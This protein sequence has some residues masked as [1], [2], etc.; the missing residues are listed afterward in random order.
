MALRGVSDQHFHLLSFF[1]ILCDIMKWS[2]ADYSWWDWRNDALYTWWTVQFDNR[3]KGANLRFYCSSADFMI[4]CIYG[5]L[6]NKMMVFIKR[7]D[8]EWTVLFRWFYYMFSW[9]SDVWSDSGCWIEIFEEMC[10]IFHFICWMMLKR[11]IGRIVCTW[12]TLKC[13]VVVIVYRN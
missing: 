1:D 8:K 2:S 6:L 5:Y 7:D 11:K 13:A 12:Q 4:P 9:Y 3:K 10:S